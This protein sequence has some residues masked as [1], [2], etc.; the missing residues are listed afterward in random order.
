[1]VIDLNQVCRICLKKG[2]RCIFKSSSSTSH[3]IINN[4]LMGPRSSEGLGADQSISLDRL[5]EK[6]RFITLLKVIFDP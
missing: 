5:A 6:L 3:E 1:M 4:A 2:T